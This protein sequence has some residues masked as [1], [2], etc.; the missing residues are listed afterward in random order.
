MEMTFGFINDDDVSKIN[1]NEGA[2]LCL[3]LFFFL[4]SFLSKIQNVFF[5][6]TIKMHFKILF[7]QG[8]GERDPHSRVI[9]ALPE[10]PGL[11]PS[12]QISFNDCS[13]FR[14]TSSGLPDP[15]PMSTH[16]FT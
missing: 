10:D 4:F 7:K 12:V 13:S 3:L 9:V 14:V 6:L 15:T 11:V 8:T 5:T 16:T 1:P 2:F